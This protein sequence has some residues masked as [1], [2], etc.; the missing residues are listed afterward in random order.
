MSDPTPDRPRRPRLPWGVL[1]MLGLVLLVEAALAADDVR[2]TTIWAAD[3]RQAGRAADRGAGRAEILCF[4]DSLAKLGLMPNVLAE[5]TG[6]SAY[7]L[8][9]SVGQATSSYVLLRRAINAGAEP[10]AVVID[11]IPH[12]LAAP[13]DYNARQ[14]A[15]LARPREIVGLAVAARDPEFLG[16]LL[17]ARWLP[18]VRCRYEL[19]AGVLGDLRGEPF[20]H[21]PAIA[22]HWRTWRVNR[23]AQPMPRADDFRGDADRWPA[24]LYP[25]SWRV[26]PVNERYLRR[27][28]DLADSRQIPVFW[29]VMPFSPEVQSRREA[30]GLDADYDRFVRR[31]RADYPDLV[32]LDA[33]HAGYGPEV[34]ID[35]IHLDHV[36]AAAISADVGEQI[37]DRLD[38][39]PADRDPTWVALRDYGDRPTGAVVEDL[40]RSRLA[41]E[42][43]VR[44]TRR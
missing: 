25:P 19:R 30:L 10:E 41:V 15:D 38:G 14:W 43:R 21:W 8:A 37:R 4:G 16:A 1:G 12:L 35:P 24:E 32:V 13:P 7:S 23:G 42:E 11:L 17:L 40:D 33:R 3:W 9:V 28:L 22:W 27:F 2:W 26:H 20:S 36:G 31:I 39:P 34:H 6:R 5:R 44:G 29:V 18:S